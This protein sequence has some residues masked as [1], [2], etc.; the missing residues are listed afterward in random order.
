[1]APSS[2]IFRKVFGAKF[3]YAAEL[4]RLKA[5]GWTCAGRDRDR[6][7]TNAIKAARAALERYPSM[8]I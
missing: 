3:T 7:M 6:A 2:I 8:P 5:A 1:M 4:A